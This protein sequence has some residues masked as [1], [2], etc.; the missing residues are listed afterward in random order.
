MVSQLLVAGVSYNNNNNSKALLPFFIALHVKLEC[1]L[2][3]THIVPK[4][5]ILI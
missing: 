5:I 4:N 3:L 2:V 1:R